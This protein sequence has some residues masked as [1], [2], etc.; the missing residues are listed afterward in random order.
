MPT[1]PEGRIFFGAL[2]NALRVAGL[3]GED[4]LAQLVGRAPADH[5]AHVPDWVAGRSLPSGPQDLRMI[6]EIERILGRAEGELIRHL[7]APV[8]RQRSVAAEID[9]GTFMPRGSEIRRVLGLF[10]LRQPEL[11]LVWARHVL[12]VDE[13]CHGAEQHQVIDFEAVRDGAR[14]FPVMYVMDEA[15]NEAPVISLTRG[16][17]TGRSHRDAALGMLVAEMILPAPLAMGE[18][19]RVEFAV[20]TVPTWA[21]S[22]QHRRAVRD[23]GCHLEMEVRFHPRAVPS[24][25]YG[26]VTSRRDEYDTTLWVDRN[27]RVTFEVNEFGPGIVGI[28]WIW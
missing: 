16:C 12:T 27:N 7:V 6:V 24:E 26:V 23:T 20:R 5:V 13:H 9:D 15:A 8:S 19:A 10:G 11:R 3:G 25:V 18:R 1:T 21:L 4:L 2:R 14:R 17:A 28:D 22:H